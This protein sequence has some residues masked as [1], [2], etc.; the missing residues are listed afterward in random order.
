[1]RLHL[2]YRG[3]FMGLF[4]TYVTVDVILYY[5]QASR[6]VMG[7]ATIVTG[8]RRGVWFTGGR[9]IP[10]SSI[11]VRKSSLPNAANEASGF[12]LVQQP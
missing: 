8:D 10:L 4:V 6:N 1:M 7:D 3:L 9:S 5:V 11:M 12:R 2:R